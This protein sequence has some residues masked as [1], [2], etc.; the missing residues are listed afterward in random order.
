MIPALRPIYLLWA[1]AWA[2]CLPAAEADR[3][4]IFRAAFAIP[5]AEIAAISPDG[6][7]VAVVSR[8]E[9]LGARVRMIDLTS[10]AVTADLASDFDDRL[11]VSQPRLRW[12]DSGRV[13]V[14]FGLREFGVVNADGR[15]IRWLPVDGSRFSERPTSHLSGEQIDRKSVV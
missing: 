6:K 1:L 4:A 13:L 9:G 7:R 15:H 5:A 2:L 14:H 3:A 11:I 12:L 8:L 10:A